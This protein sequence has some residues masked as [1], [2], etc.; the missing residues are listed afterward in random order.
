MMTATLGKVALT[1]GK[2]DFTIFEPPSGQTCAAYAADFLQTATGYLENPEA[3]TNCQYCSSSSGMDY[4]EQMG[5]R[6][7]RKWS[8]WSI[9]LLFCV[10]NV[11]FIFVFT[12]I[13][14]VRPLY[15]R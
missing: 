13:W 2:Q 1:C 12:Y 15:K 7:D 10:S 11:F 5:Y 6:W 14:V 8:D 3:T 4:V 9:I